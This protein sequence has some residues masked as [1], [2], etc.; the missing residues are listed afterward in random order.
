MYY[1]KVAPWDQYPKNLY[2][3]EVQ[4]PLMVIEDFFSAGWPENQRDDLKRW[5]Y[6]VVNN[7]HYKDKRHGP[8]TLLFIY[9]LNVKLVEALHLL[10]LDYKNTWRTDV[11]TKHEQLENERR[12][13]VYWPKNLS[14]KESLNPYEVI[15]QCFKKLKPQEY[16]DQ[17]REWLHVALYNHAAD[18]SL[19]AGQI[20]TLYENM[21]RLYSAAWIV[22]QRD[23]ENTITHKAWGNV[24]FADQPDELKL[25]ESGLLREL[26]PELTAAAE[27]GLKEIKKLIV[28]RMPL[29]SLIVYLGKHDDPFTYYLLVLIDDGEKTPE[30][31]ISN[32]VEDN[33]RYLANVY[34]I[35]H[36][37]GSA[38]AGINSGQRFWNTAISKGKIIYQAPELEL[39]E[40]KAIGQD[41]LHCRAEFHWQRWG[42]QGKEFLKGA[43]RYAADNNYKLAAFL[44]HQSVESVLKAVIQV[45]LGYRVQIHN[46][47]R[48]LRLTLL[49]TDA[50]KNVFEL[51]TPEG[52][53]IF[54]LLQSSYSQSRYKN[55]FD[56]EKESIELLAKRVKLLFDM[57]EGVYNQYLANLQRS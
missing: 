33:C 3:K 14:D 5:R 54:S 19:A 6:Y 43:E 50:F 8:G 46:L 23:T 36:K 9:D 48:L 22:H 34:A 52:T 35:A 10:W 21:L 42:V 31:E 17:L 1:D 4:Y 44:L 40:V 24:K 2:F 15:G 25:D 49:F 13:W 53:Q 39:P 26:N 47:S 18:E 28:E 38:I 56:P 51:G 27:L 12:E 57:A 7:E 37:A 32:K 29:V 41:L 11:A 45:V 20:I 30:H 16:R 55:A